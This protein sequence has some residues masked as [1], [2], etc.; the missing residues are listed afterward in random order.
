MKIDA[1]MIS[2]ALVVSPTTY[3]DHSIIWVSSRMAHL[4]TTSP[5]GSLTDDSNVTCLELS[6]Y[7]TLFLL[8]FLMVDGATA[9]PGT[10]GRSLGITLTSSASLTSLYL[11]NYQF[12]PDSVPPSV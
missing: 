2:S 7:L 5:S 8:L 4:L 6:H 12:F 1:P 10:Q 11:L 3:A 9:V